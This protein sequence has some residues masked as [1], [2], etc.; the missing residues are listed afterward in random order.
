MLPCEYSFPTASTLFVKGAQT[1]ENVLTTDFTINNTLIDTDS[2]SLVC[3][4]AC[5]RATSRVRLLVFSL[6]F[7]SWFCFVL[8]ASVVFQ[9]PPNVGKIPVL[10]YT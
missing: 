3:L 6:G 5:L 2:L 10:F 1:S 8:L 9:G 7:F 4:L